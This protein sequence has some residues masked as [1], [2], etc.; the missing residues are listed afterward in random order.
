MYTYN[1]YIMTYHK[2]SG[3]LPFYV[4]A[5]AYLSHRS[6][7]ILVNFWKLQRANVIKFDIAQKSVFIIHNKLVTEIPTGYLLIYPSVRPFRQHVYQHQP[8]ITET[9]IS[10]QADDW[11]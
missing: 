11:W 7:F 3:F 6:N 10:K 1:I 4:E 2:H 9:F 8:V 5:I